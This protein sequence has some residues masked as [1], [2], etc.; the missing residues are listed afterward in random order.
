MK[1]LQIE[2]D[3]VTEVNAR[4]YRVDYFTSPEQ[5]S[6]EFM[7]ITK[8]ALVSHVIESEMNV[9]YSLLADTM[10]YEQIPVN[11]YQW[12]EES[13]NEAVLSYLQANLE[14]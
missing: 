3:S 4:T 6:T 9:I 11:A 12:V 1:T 13:L 10:E 2:L 8:T 14:G 7:Y 5:E